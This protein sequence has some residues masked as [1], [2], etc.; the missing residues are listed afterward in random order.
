MA[1]D[2]IDWSTVKPGYVHLPIYQE[3]KAQL[4]N[5]DNQERIIGGEE[6]VPNSIPYQVGLLIQ[7][8]KGISFCGGSL[9]SRKS[10]LT[11]AHC[12]DNATEIEIR[13]GAHRIKEEENT[14]IRL[15]AIKYI[16]HAGWNKKT[17]QNDIGIIEL[18]EEVALNENVQ[19]VTLPTNSDMG[20]TFYGVTG[21]ISGWGL[22]GGNSTDISPVLKQLFAKVMKNSN[23]N[24]RYLGGIKSSHICTTGKGRV[25][26]SSGDSGGPLVYGNMQIGIASFVLRWEIGWPTVFTR[27]TSYL[28]WIASNS[29]V[30]IIK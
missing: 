26:A 25:G 3:I 15:K 12:L 17:L 4:Q 14:Q 21:R 1:E 16:Q 13:L 29:D 9:I 24:V 27:V 28:D 20:N 6:A 19:L 7:V 30:T 5:L 10:V 8:P 23:C 2:D 22:T 18:A 11:A